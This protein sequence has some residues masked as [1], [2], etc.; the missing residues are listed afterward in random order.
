MI[1][2]KDKTY[3]EINESSNKLEYEEESNAVLPENIIISNIS[4]EMEKEQ[5]VNI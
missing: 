3:L 5:Y 4:S 2:N 1:K